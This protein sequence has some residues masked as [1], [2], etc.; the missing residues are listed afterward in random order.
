MS[1][2]LTEA[3]ALSPT[4]IKYDP[5]FED[6]SCPCQ[7]HWLNT[8]IQWKYLVLAHLL[9]LIKLITVSLLN[10]MK[11]GLFE[12][13][14]L[15]LVESNEFALVEWIPSDLL[16]SESCPNQLAQLSHPE[17]FSMLCQA[18]SLCLFRNQTLTEQPHK[19]ATTLV[20]TTLFWENRFCTWDIKLNSPCRLSQR[21]KPTK[22]HE[23]N[24]Q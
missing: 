7:I 16:E 21:S 6:G 4:W 15:P 10:P 17:E 9:S 14:K 11:L 13:H 3:Q 19:E 5:S 22:Y 24:S 8:P 12:Q 18:S 2:K 1:S 20:T 23:G